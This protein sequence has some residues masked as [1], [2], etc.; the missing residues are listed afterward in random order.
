VV[1]RGQLRGDTV[2]PVA[3]GLRRAALKIDQGVEG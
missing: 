3:F 2:V 1:G